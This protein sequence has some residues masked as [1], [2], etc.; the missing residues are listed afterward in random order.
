MPKW[1]IYLCALFGLVFFLAGCALFFTQVLR[2]RKQ[3]QAEVLDAE[4]EAFQYTDEGQTS[5][6][7]RAKY[8]VRFET[9]EGRPIRTPILGSLAAGDPETV[10]KKLRENPAGSHRPIYYLPARPENIV[11]DPLARRVGVSLLFLTI[12]ATILAVSGLLLYQ[13]QPLEW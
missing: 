4:V 12:G 8:D 1:I 3:T 5:T 6:R 7:Y 13:T 2:G 10:K 9:A 11:T